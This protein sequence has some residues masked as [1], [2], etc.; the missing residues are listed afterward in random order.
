MDIGTIE[1]LQSQTKNNEEYFLPLHENQHMFKKIQIEVKEVF[2]SDITAVYMN[3]IEP[4]VCHI[5]YCEGNDI[6]PRSVGGTSQTLTCP[7]GLA[8]ERTFYCPEIKKPKWRELNNTC[9]IAP[10]LLRANKNI[11]LTAGKKDESI[12]FFAVS[13][14]VESINVEPSL[15]D[16]IKPVPYEPGLYDVFCLT[17]TELK[18]YLF[19]VKNNYGNVSFVSSFLI[20][21]TN[22]PLIVNWTETYTFYSGAEIK[23]VSLFRAVGPNLEITVEPSLPEGLQM[24]GYTGT[25]SGTC[26]KESSDN[27]IFTAKNNYGSKFVT[28]HIE[29]VISDNI[30]IVDNIEEFSFVKE[31]TYT[32]LE[33]FT[34]IGR[35]LEFEIQTGEL[36]K[37]L[38][39]S[40]YDGTISGTVSNE[41]YTTQTIVISVKNSVNQGT[42]DF[43][44]SVISAT[45][46][47]II[48]KKDEYTIK[49]NEEIENLSLFKVAGENLVFSVNPP[50]PNG[51]TL[52]TS[53]G[54]ISGKIT[55]ATGN[56]YYTFYM[57]NSYGTESLSI[58]LSVSEPLEPV[59]TSHLSEFQLSKNVYIHSTTLFETFG[60]DLRYKVEPTLPPGILFSDESGVISGKALTESPETLY[61]FTAYNTY[62]SESITI[63]INVIVLYCEAQDI[64]PRTELG[65]SSVVSCSGVNSGEH[66]IDCIEEDGVAVWDNEYD[67]CKFPVGLLIGIIVAAI[68]IV[69]LLAM[70]IAY[71]YFRK[72][73]KSVNKRE[74]KKQTVLV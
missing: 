11:Q 64:Y 1:I 27:Y 69:I 8:G 52:D 9:P 68:V 2:D 10:E 58:Y 15:P 23:E 4:Y 43:T 3:E 21:G 60:R 20:K 65:Q 14:F 46:P 42:M 6:L 7:N 38:T 36:P 45:N 53:T 56:K 37:G 72:N 30:I 66:H 48:D 25:I 73:V 13:G 41:E 33:L 71:C 31:V 44:P 5:F 62:G 50:L 51:L 12:E 17:E 19:N 57:R 32:S 61:T 40:K 47:I 54:V 18:E 28:V 26:I 29:C 49:L 24:S 63:K 70:I 22:E 39:L 35:E 67:N 16:C 59:F 55:S 34:V 74:E